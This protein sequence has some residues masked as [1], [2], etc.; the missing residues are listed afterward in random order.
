MRSNLT[1]VLFLKDRHEFNERFINFFL[2]NNI[3]YNFNLLISDGGKKKLD[4]KILNIIK[5]NQFIKYIRFP[6][7]K[8]Y[9]IFYNKIYKTLKKVKTEYLFFVANDDF[10]IFETLLKCIKF[11]NQHKNKGYI[12][13]CGTLINFQCKKNL[14][15]FNEIQNIKSLYGYVKLDHRNKFTRFE[16]YLKNFNDIPHNCIIKKK[17]LLKIYKYSRNL[18]GN[19]IEFKDHF[20]NLF[21]V[22]IGRIKFFNK[23]LLLHETHFLSSEG[24][25]RGKILL[26]TFNNENFLNDLSKFDYILS[27]Y[28]GSK[29]NFIINK[30]YKYV[31]SKM[32][33]SLKLINEPSL[34]QIS[35]I[36]FQKIRRKVI[37]KKNDISYINRNNLDKNTLQTIKQIENYIIN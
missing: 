4:K 2:K 10:F 15:G 6:E 3:N 11:L 19:N 27:R 5:R 24:K 17:I 34:K 14:D 28:L 29:K 20:T 9:E 33:N 30:Y 36:L 37:T 32:L 7:D 13:S 31:L 16:N 22:I 23:P 8:S 18:F 12:G 21:T 26:S 1:I 35:K 25:K